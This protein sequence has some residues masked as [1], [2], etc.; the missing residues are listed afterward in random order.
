MKCTVLN[1]IYI[2]LKVIFYEWT[3]NNFYYFINKTW[4]R[5]S[6]LNFVKQCLTVVYILMH[7]KLLFTILVI[8]TSQY[9]G[10]FISKCFGNTF[11]SADG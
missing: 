5:S 11:L 7:N 1:E 10:T 6:E 2:N 3:I 4:G 9:K 8:I